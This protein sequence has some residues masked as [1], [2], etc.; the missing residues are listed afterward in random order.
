MRF[1]ASWKS[2]ALA[3][4]VSTLATP[5]TAGFEPIR[6]MHRIASGPVA[7]YAPDRVM[8]RY[9]DT[10]AK[11]GLARDAVRARVGAGVARSYATM[12]DLEA[13]SLPAGASVEATIAQLERDP[14]VEYAH[15]DHIFSTDVVP[16][17]THFDQEWGLNN[18]GQSIDGY[19]GQ[20]TGVDIDAPEAWEHGTGTPDTIVADIDEGIDF[21]HPDLAENIWTNTGE[22]PDNGIDDDGNGFVDDIH[23]WDFLHNDATTYDGANDPT[24]GTDFHG[25]HT[26]GTIGAVGNNGQGVTGVCWHVKI[27]SLKFLQGSGEE[28]DA[29]SCIDYILLMKQRGVNVRA[30]NASWGGPSGSQSLR[31]A[32]A[33][34]GDADIV[35]CASA[36][37]GGSDARGD[38]NDLYPSFPASFDLPNI[39]S[40]GA[41]TRYNQAATFSNYGAVTVDLY[42]PGGLVASTGPNGN[43]YYASGTSMAAPHVTGTVALIA[44][45]VPSLSGS[46]IKA[47]ILQTTVPVP[48]SPP[49]V[50]GGR[51]DLKSA[52]EAALGDDGGEDPPPPPP[53]PSPVAA[54]AKFVNSKK[55]LF[56]YGDE[57]TVTAVIEVNGVAMPFMKYSPQD[58]RPD[59]KYDR[60][61]GKAPGRTN[62]FL[63]KHQQVLLTVFDPATGQRSAPLPF[64]R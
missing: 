37:N 7:A 62:F 23:G 12:P 36:G 52:V 45:L 30:I 44:S 34:A 41:W 64:E 49:T 55:T 3:T 1:P 61:G 26:S 19:P 42:A 63:P 5:A 40:V 21:T 18:T 4:L 31:D 20:A 27:M 9:R 56:V 39:I 16:N 10:A 35:F 46:A 47:L 32:I 2:F 51:L 50:T 24:N 8:V 29:I 11:T 25:T 43:Y 58:L 13:L 14:R 60:I 22:V 17:D 48:Y 38:N 28:S 59:G 54:S 15:P 6:V 57:L 33:R 53:P